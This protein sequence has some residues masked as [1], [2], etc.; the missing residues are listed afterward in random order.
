MTNIRIPESVTK[1]DDST[2][3]GCSGL[4]SI[5]IPKSVT[6]IGDRAFYGCENLTIITPSGSY[7]ETYAIENNIPVKNP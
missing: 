2:F 5:T 3:E 4:T 7:A 1:I 6:K